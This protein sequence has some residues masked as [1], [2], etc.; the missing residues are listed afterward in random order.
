M[1]QGKYFYLDETLEVG[2]TERTEPNFTAQPWFWP[3][4]FI[5]KTLLQ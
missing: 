2:A 3:Y 1:Y 4:S 5:P